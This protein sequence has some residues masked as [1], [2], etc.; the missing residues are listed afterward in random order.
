[1]E[2]AALIANH[3]SIQT[4]QLYDRRTRSI[5]IAEVEKIKL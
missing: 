3:E 4:T 5:S 2:R 1:L